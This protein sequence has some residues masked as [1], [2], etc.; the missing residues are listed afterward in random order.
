MKV[1]TIRFKKGIKKKIRQTQKTYDYMCPLND[2]KLGDYVLLE[3]KIH[4]REDFQVGRIESVVN[5]EDYDDGRKQLPEGFVVC[6]I[7][8]QK[9]RERC[10]QI[11]QMKK[12]T[13][14]QNRMRAEKIRQDQM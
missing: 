10:H 14:R 11:R 6:R 12:K 9:F 4:K 13:R 7:P 5:L 3:V 1:V 8:V 2:I